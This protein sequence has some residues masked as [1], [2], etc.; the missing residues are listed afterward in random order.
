MQKQIYIVGNGL[1][2][3]SFKKQ[4]HPSIKIAATFWQQDVKSNLESS[5]TLI[6]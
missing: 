2:E 5:V 4:G 3:I 6:L 1:C